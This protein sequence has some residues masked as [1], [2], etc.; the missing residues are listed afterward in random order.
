MKF[1]TFHPGAVA[2][3]VFCGRT[4]TETHPLVKQFLKTFFIELYVWSLLAV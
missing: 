3:H 2:G 4:V 1:W